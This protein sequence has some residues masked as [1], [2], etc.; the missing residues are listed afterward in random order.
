M[1]KEHAG[2]VLPLFADVLMNPAFPED[3]VELAK[4]QAKS[5]VSRRNDDPQQIAFREFDQVL[6]GEESPYARTTEYATLDA[7]TPDDLG[8]FHDQ[9]FHPNNVILGV[10][11]DFETEAM[12]QQLEAAFA[13]WEK[14]EGFERPDPPKV[15]AAGGEGVFFAPKADVTQSTVL[16]GHVGEVRRDNPDYFPLTVMN[17]VLAGGFSSRL[18]QNVRDDQGLA[19]AVFGAYTAPYDRDGE[20]YAGVMT[21]SETT[22]EAAESVLREVEK[23]REAAP[24]DEEMDQAKESFLNAFVFNFDTRRE[25]VD[26][27]ATYEYYGYPKDFLEKTKEEVEAVTADDVLRVS[28]QYLKPDEAKVLVVGNEADFG[29]PLSTLGDVQELD[30]AIPSP[31]TEEAPEATDETAA[32]GRAVLDEVVAALGGAEA[33]D[34]VEAMRQEGTQTS[35]TPDNQQIEVSFTAEQAFPDRGRFT[36]Q[37]PGGEVQITMNGERMELTSPQGTMAAPPPLERQIRSGL[38]RDPVYLLAHRDRIEVQHVGEE[39]VDGRPADVLLVTP[40]DGEAEPFRLFVDQETKQ[41]LQLTYQGMSMQG[42]PVQSRDV[43]ADYEEAGGV[44]IPH[45]LVQ[46]QDG[47]KAQETELTDV[48]INPEL[49]EGTFEIGS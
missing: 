40:P 29:E 18:F 16:I 37:T 42:A 19:Y 26:R 9:Y 28:N 10:W 6:Y 3:K 20:F 49:E 33:I 7:I 38:W 27:M 41:P 13:D 32:K 31:E 46:Y 15:T 2:E 8:A 21:K 12:V 36:V 5:M 45:R 4:T 22:V 30:I 48:Q 35:T 24:T 34:A 23:M 47:Q 1:L 14:A 39:D 44:M 17:E 11:G 25:V 43:F